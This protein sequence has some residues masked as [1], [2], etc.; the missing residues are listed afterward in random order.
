MVMGKMETSSGPLFPQMAC[1][2]EETGQWEQET[3]AIPN[4]SCLELNTE[5]PFFN[6]SE[7]LPA[8][9]LPSDPVSGHAKQSQQSQGCWGLAQSLKVSL[10]LYRASGV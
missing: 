5:E 6:V 1:P 4:L 2:K 8:V 3:S 9:A 7:W 10:G